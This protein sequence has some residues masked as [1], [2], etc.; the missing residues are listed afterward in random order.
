[1]HALSQPPYEQWWANDPYYLGHAQFIG[2]VS[3]AIIETIEMVF[4]NIQ[5]QWDEQHAEH[6]LVSGPE[7]ALWVYQHVPR[8]TL[9]LREDSDAKLT[10]QFRNFQPATWH[11]Y[12]AMPDIDPTRDSVHQSQYP[13]CELY[14]PIAHSDTVSIEQYVEI[15]NRLAAELWYN[16]CLSLYQELADE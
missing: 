9:V 4:D 6:E 5:D 11:F 2:I 10:R 3:K 12:F 8:P 1:M 15:L 16:Q 7:F 13:L 14:T